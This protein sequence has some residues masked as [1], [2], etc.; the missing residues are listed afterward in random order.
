MLVMSQIR[1]RRSPSLDR[2]PRCG[3]PWLH[4]SAESAL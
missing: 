1:P 3:L 2:R 4:I